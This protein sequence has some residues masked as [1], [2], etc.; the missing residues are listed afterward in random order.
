MTISVIG[1]LACLL[2]G[3][4]SHFLSREWNT[5]AAALRAEMTIAFS[6]VEHFVDFLDCAAGGVGAFLHLSSR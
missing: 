3:Q 1:I 6:A 5:I 4:L 2:L